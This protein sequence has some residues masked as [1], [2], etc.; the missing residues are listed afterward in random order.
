MN[1]S[2]TLNHRLWNFSNNYVEKWHHIDDYYSNITKENY[3]VSFVY[4]FISFY[5]WQKKLDNEMIFLDTTIA[6]KSDLVMIKYFKIFQQIMCDTRLFNGLK[7]DKSNSTDHFFNNNF[8]EMISI[9]IKPD[10]VLSF[11]HFKA[12]IDNYIQT[13]TPIMDF[14]NGV[15]PDENRYRWEK[16][17][18][19]HICLL[20]FLNTFGYDYQYTNETKL[21]IL[22]ENIETIG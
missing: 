16:I 13:I 15:A 20:A 3:F 2:E 6:L 10:S 11:P 17:Q 18:I 9:F 4:R 1:A 19:L 8:E 5:A 22:S 7:Y 14:I 12:D 21:R